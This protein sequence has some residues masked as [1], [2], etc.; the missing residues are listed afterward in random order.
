[1]IL[2]SR[3]KGCYLEDIAANTGCSVSTVQRSLKRQGPPARRRQGIRVSKL[4]DFK[5]HIDHLLTENVWNAEVIFAEIK[6]RGY[7][8]EV[9]ILRN[10]IQPRRVMHPG[11]VTTRYET[12]SG[13]QLQHDWGELMVE[14]G[15]ELS[16]VYFSVI[17]LGYSRRF[18][19]WAAFSNDAEHTYESLIRSFEWFAGVMISGSLL[20]YL[21]DQP[22]P[23]YNT[24]PLR[25]LLPDYWWEWVPP[26]AVAAPV[27]ME[28]VDWHDCRFAHWLP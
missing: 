28:C 21:L 13:H 17:T 9:T 4:D 10:Y 23:D 12:E 3:E 16:K 11:K 26:L 5:L 27:V 7:T 15:G 20:P 22:L 18:Y 24:S 2:K 19:A 25:W 6:E 14:V 1:M 8:G